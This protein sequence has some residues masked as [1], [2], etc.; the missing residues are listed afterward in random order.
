M[1]PDLTAFRFAGR[2]FPAQQLGLAPRF[3]LGKHAA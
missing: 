1:T 3:P 2:A